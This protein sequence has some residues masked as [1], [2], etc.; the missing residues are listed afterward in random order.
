[1][2]NG[3]PFDTGERNGKGNVAARS[4]LADRVAF[5]PRRVGESYRP[6][7]GSEYPN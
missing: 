4:E 5:P 1:V 2:P 6:D 3:S 7:L